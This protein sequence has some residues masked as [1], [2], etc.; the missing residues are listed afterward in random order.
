MK[1]YSWFSL[2]LQLL[3]LFP[4]PPSPLIQ[5]ILLE[6]SHHSQDL[7]CHAVA[8]EIHG[9]YSRWNISPEFPTCHLITTLE[10][11]AGHLM[12]TSNLVGEKLCSLAHLPSGCTCSLVWVSYF[13]EILTIHQA[14]SSKKPSLLSFSFPFT[15]LFTVNQQVQA[16]PSVLS[17]I[18]S[19]L[20][21]LTA[22]SL[23]WAGISTSCITFQAFHQSLCL[24][25][26]HSYTFLCYHKNNLF[27]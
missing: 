14:Y 17:Q 1:F 13:P 16:L 9:L 2:L 26:F 24:P 6:L 22:Y 5:A 8:L 15:C 27:T 4:E 10:L 11:S 18:F 3:R 19:F 7:I 20:L 21:I 23:L 25:F 12:S